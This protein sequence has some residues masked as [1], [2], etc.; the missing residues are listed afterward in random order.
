MML[1]P[2]T[3]K[4]EISEAHSQL[5]ER[6]QERGVRFYRNIGWPSGND[7]FTIYWQPQ[8]KFWVMLQSEP[9]H[10][11]CGYGLQDP[12]SNR[13]LEFTVQINPS[14]IPSNR[15]TGGAF[16]RDRTGR[17]YLCHNGA[18]TK[19][20]SSLGRARFIAQFEDD[21]TSVEWHDGSTSTFAVLGRLDEP[22]L[23]RK[24]SR[25][26]HQ[27]AEFKSGGS[28]RSEPTE[29]ALHKLLFTPEFAGKRKAYR[30]PNKIEPVNTHGYVV[31][32]LQNELKG[33]WEALRTAL[34]DLYLFD[35][36]R[37][38]HLFEV[39]TDY[40]R[41]SVYE[42]VGQLMLHGALEVK[43]VK[44]VLV[45]PGRPVGDTGLR[46]QE[47]GVSVLQ[48]SWHGQIPIFRNLQQIV[49]G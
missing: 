1:E 13:S 25:F 9:T 20:H 30:V 24:L 46:L 6:L 14:K 44:R 45:V 29:P 28:S 23:L 31:T 27:V 22:Q 34:I 43:P 21:L 7:D 49:G 18:L 38:T 16:L 35:G 8:H 32:A 4:K 42:G 17:Y 33:R 19:G 5:K 37:M 36:D 40:G 2:L 39:K 26:I 48:Y 12:T 11:W 10:Y 41:G 15:R 47:L 3:L